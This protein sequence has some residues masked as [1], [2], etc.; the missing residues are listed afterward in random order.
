MLCILSASVPVYTYRCLY[1]SKYRPPLIGGIWPTHLTS[2][3]SPQ[4]M[5]VT[6]PSPLQIVALPWPMK[7]RIVDLACLW[8][9]RKLQWIL[10]T[11][12]H[13]VKWHPSLSQ[14]GEH[15]YIHYTSLNTIYDT[16][17]NHIILYYNLASYSIVQ[18]SIR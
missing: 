3:L 12:L 14:D 9:L 18:Y 10:V 15:L 2:P 16:I 7:F 4:Q 5:H 13:K 6:H 1:V 11:S 8:H 17:L